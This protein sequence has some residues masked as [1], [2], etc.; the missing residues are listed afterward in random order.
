[1]G[2]RVVALDRALS[3]FSGE[4]EL[5]GELFNRVGLHYKAFSI[6]P[7]ISFLKTSRMLG[8]A[9]FS[10][11]ARASNRA[12]EL[13]GLFGPVGVKSVASSG[14]A[15]SDIRQRE[16]CFRRCR[17]VEEALAVSVDLEPGLS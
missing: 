10:K 4:T 2:E 17:F 11:G 6:R 3:V 15:L 7:G 8:S 16:E 1:M 13:L 9:P 5:A 14:S 12:S